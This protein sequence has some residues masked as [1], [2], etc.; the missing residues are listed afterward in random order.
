[1]TIFPTEWRAKDR[2][3]VGVVRTNQ[4][5]LEDD[6]FPFGARPI[7]KGKL[8][9]SFKEWSFW[10]E[11]NWRTENTKELQQKSWKIFGRDLLSNYATKNT[12]RPSHVFCFG[13]LYTDLF[14]F[15]CFF[16]KQLLSEFFFFL[17]SVCFFFSG[18]TLE[19]N[20]KT[21]TNC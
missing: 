20:K 2:N 17:S 13:E 16:L 10:N 11:N 1:M 14:E 5:W 7:F 9:V 21:P 8:L 15:T 19:G 18:G 3:K 4:W 6:S 12:T